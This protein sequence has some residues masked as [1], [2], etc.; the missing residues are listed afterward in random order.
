MVILRTISLLAGAAAIAFSIRHIR[1]TP[2]S[3]AL[4]L[5]FLLV[6]NQHVDL[7]EPLFRAER[8]VL[9]L[10]GAPRVKSDAEIVAMAIAI[11]DN[12]ATFK[13]SA[14]T[15]N[16]VLFKFSD[17]V[18]GYSWLAVSDDGCKLLF[19]TTIQKTQPRA[20][21]HARPLGLRA[22]DARFGQ[23]PGGEICLCDGV[24]GLI[25]LGHH[26]PHSLQRSC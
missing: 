2:L 16:H 10:A 15:S 1:P 20:R 19:G 14:D 18:N 3:H 13:V 7:Y 24:S 6:P 21:R 23:V 9:H 11:G 26:N 12:V 22:I 5:Q 8:M 17:R 4:R 25:G